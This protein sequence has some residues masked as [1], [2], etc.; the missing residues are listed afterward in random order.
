MINN[1][2]WFIKK[3]TLSGPFADTLNTL[4]ATIFGGYKIGI[5]LLVINGLITFLLLFLFSNKR[6]QDS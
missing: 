6:T 3:L 2:E 4:S 1:A 5:E